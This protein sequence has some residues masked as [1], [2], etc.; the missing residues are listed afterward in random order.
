MVQTEVRKALSASFATF[1]PSILQ[2]AS[3]I[4]GRLEHFRTETLASFDPV[5]KGKEV[6]KSDMDELLDST[7]GPESF[8]VPDMPVTNSRANLYIYLNAAVSLASHASS[9]TT[10]ANVL[11]WNSS[12]D[13]RSSTITHFLAT[14]TTDTKYV[15][16]APD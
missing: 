11:T 2:S 13:D 1:V 3:Q 14:Y 6:I 8:V 7:I 9:V 12:S 15:N 16:Q 4:A 5:E 10:V